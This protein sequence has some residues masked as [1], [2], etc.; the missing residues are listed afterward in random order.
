MSKSS[1]TIFILSLVTLTACQQP[2][3]SVRL[4]SPSKSIQAQHRNFNAHMSQSPEGYRVLTLVNKSWFSDKYLSRVIRI[5]TFGNDGRARF[6]DLPVFM[7]KN[8]QLLIPGS[9]ENEFIQMGTY[10]AD[11]NP[12]LVNEKFS[13]WRGVLSKEI[14]L[15]ANVKTVKVTWLKGVD[16]LSSDELLMMNFTTDVPSN[17]PRLTLTDKSTIK[18]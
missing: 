18:I 2:S 16:F 17:A 3:T 15:P 7:H 6:S 9:T 14:K 5:R 10:Q 13:D 8:G 12:K 1:L 4:T 11:S